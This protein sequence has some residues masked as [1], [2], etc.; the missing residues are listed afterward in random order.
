M[1]VTIDVHSKWI[2]ALPLR[3]ATASMM[4]SALQTFFANFGFSEEIV[5]DN[6]PQFITQTFQIFVKPMESNT[7]S[8]HLTIHLQMGQ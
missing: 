2:E 4:I 7:C 5:T 3:K 6:D 8:P 1:L